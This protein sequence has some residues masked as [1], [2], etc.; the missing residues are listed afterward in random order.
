LFRIPQTELLAL[1]DVLMQEKDADRRFEAALHDKELPHTVYSVGEP[2]E[3]QTAQERIREKNAWQRA[4][5][6]KMSKNKNY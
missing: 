3:G 2:R 5:Q 4:Q 1:A 6:L